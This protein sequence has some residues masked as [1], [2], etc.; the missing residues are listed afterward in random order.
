M[1]SSSP[2]LQ[3]VAAQGQFPQLN[4]AS[5]FPNRL[6]APAGQPITI[7]TPPPQ[8][9]YTKTPY[10]TIPTPVGSVI[11][12]NVTPSVLNMPAGQ[13]ATAPT[14]AAVK[15]PKATEDTATDTLETDAL[16][17][18]G[19]ETPATKP[20][21]KAA[22]PEDETDA[23]RYGRITGEKIT[24]LLEVNPQL[25]TQVESWDDKFDL[26]NAIGN[27]D[28][29]LNDIKE[30]FWDYQ[31]SGPRF[32]GPG[33]RI[34]RFM[35]RQSKRPFR[36]ILKRVG[37]SISRRLPPEAQGPFNDV[38]NWFTNPKAPALNLNKKPIGSSTLNSTSST[39]ST[40]SKTKSNSKSKLNLDFDI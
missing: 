26:E 28:S 2:I 13:I 39:S 9:T 31:I 12:L 7:L 27:P 24:D 14:N 18:D 20:A 16:T 17:E 22:I 15:T 10:G 38:V 33:R 36:F 34:V 1:V 19:T 29:R 3:S 40:G 6:P 11:Y 37:A 8:V 30:N 4:K 32:L 21:T 25:L 5:Y 35:S 23:E